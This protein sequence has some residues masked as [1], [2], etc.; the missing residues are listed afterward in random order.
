MSTNDHITFAVYLTLCITHVIFAI[1]IE[2]SF[3]SLPRIHNDISYVL[4]K[5]ENGRTTVSA[6]RLARQLGLF[7][8][9]VLELKR[10][11]SRKRW[12][13]TW[14]ELMPEAFSW[15]VIANIFWRKKSLSI[16]VL[17]S[18]HQSL[19]KN[20]VKYFVFCW[21]VYWCHIYVL[22]IFMVP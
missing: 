15:Y 4:P 12:N 21:R 6:L 11:L 5:E 2:V 19:C 9:P 8:G 22:F 14:I 10:I 20:K 17:K 3:Q 13:S 7:S 18:N 1:L 16:T